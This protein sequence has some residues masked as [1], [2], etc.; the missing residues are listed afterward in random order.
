[1]DHYSKRYVIW[2][3]ICTWGLWGILI[4]LIKL[5]VTTFGTPLA[6]IPFV[7][8][9][10]MPAIIGI[11]LKK[12]YGS[13]EK[14]RVFIQSIVNPK[15]H[16]GW[17]ILI[18]VLAFISCYLPMMF[19]GATMQKPLYVALIS[20]PIM[21]VGGGI[22]EIGWRG[23]L[24]PALQKRFSA[25]SSTMIVSI[26]WAIW[27]LPLWF[28]SGTNQSE[29]DFISFIITTI[30]ISFVLTTILNATKSI[31][32]CIVFHALLNSFWSVYVPND[33]ISPAF[34]TLIF[35]IFIFIIYKLVIKKKASY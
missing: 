28:I 3:F 4:S 18:I 20:F 24:Q 32:M 7:F 15:H 35:G 27:H 17:Y 34:S 9:G 31:F 33:R 14:F 22:E 21:I 5:D 10:I 30:A 25:F 23:S 2:A 1:M 16:F 13:K 12:K 26:I 11:S 29:R 6:M 19:D 8:G